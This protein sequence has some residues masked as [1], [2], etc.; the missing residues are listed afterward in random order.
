[1]TQPASGEPSWFVAPVFAV[2]DGHFASR[3]TRVLL[4]NLDFLPDAPKPT[5]TQLEAVDLLEAIAASPEFVL[6][7]TMKPGDIQLI[8]SHVTFHNRTAFEDWPQPER[9]RHLLRLWLSVPN[10]RPLSPALA[11]VYGDIR[12]GAIRGGATPHPIN[13]LASALSKRHDGAPSALSYR[14]RN[15]GRVTSSVTSSK[16]TSTGIPTVTASGGHSRM[17]AVRRT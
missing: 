13:A 17:L 7:F 10:S 14:G 4:R 8:N 5:P 15:C 16:T 9:H 12:A 6:A 1:M 2:T 3:F 11:P